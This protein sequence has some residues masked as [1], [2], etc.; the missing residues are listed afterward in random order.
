LDAKP[1]LT[2]EELLAKI[3]ISGHVLGQGQL[4]GT[5]QR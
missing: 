3:K 1:E 2:K 4:L 5:Y